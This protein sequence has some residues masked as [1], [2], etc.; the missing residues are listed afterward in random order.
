MCSRR[1]ET[2]WSAVLIGV[3]AKWAFSPVKPLFSRGHPVLTCWLCGCVLKLQ[4]CVFVSTAA[5]AYPLSADYCS[6]LPTPSK[7]DTCAAQLKRGNSNCGV[8][9]VFGAAAQ[10]KSV[11]GDVSNS[12]CLLLSGYENNTR[13]HLF[14]LSI[15]PPREETS[16]TLNQLFHQAVKYSTEFNCSVHFI[17]NPN[18]QTQSLTIY[19]RLFFRE[20]CA[21]LSAVFT[22]CA[23]PVKPPP[24]KSALVRTCLCVCECAYLR[25]LW[26]ILSLDRLAFCP[27]LAYLRILLI[28]VWDMPGKWKGQEIR[29]WKIMQ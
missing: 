13:T 18:M 10:L 19:P 22:H 16:R 7:G 21:P 12:H 9:G 26:I 23:A 24:W 5:E 4:T 11:F 28:N 29:F 25:D 27:A 8:W 1:G 2:R 3:S 15:I 17:N 6:A 20:C 14:F